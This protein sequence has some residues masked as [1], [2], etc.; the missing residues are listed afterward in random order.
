MKRTAYDSPAL[1]ISWRHKD[2]Q[3]GQREIIP[4]RP[5]WEADIKALQN[6]HPEEARDLLG[7]DPFELKNI[8][9][10]WVLNERAEIQCIPTD[11]VTIHDGEGQMVISLKDMKALYKNDL[12]VLEIL[13]KAD[14]K[15]PLYTSISLGPDNVSFLR[16]HLVLEGMAY[17]VSPTVTGQ[18]VDVERLYDNIMHRFRYGGLSEK[19]IYVDE[20][21]RHMANTHQL[22]MGVLIDAL[23]EQGDTNRALA[24]CRKWQKELPQENVPYTDAAFSMARCY[25]QTHH[26]KQG[27]EII[28]S[29]LRRSDEWLTWIE[30][31]HPQRRSGSD[32]NRYSWLKTMGEALTVAQHFN[33]TNIHHQYYPQYELHIRQY[34][35]D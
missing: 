15:R 16:D 21:V 19:G 6:E 28:N 3:E 14:W 1:P 35:K 18:Q 7:E 11:S 30:T 4:V 9:A 29:L 24:E 2:Y 23:L 10:K 22:I 12:M 25:Y 8:I 33:R 20:D 17:R 32:Y 34:P 26:S 5:E 31:I 13:S 27:D